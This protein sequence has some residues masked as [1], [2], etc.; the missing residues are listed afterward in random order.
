PAHG[1]VIIT[2]RV[3]SI[4]NVLVILERTGFFGMCVIQINSLKPVARLSAYKGKGGPCYDTGRTAEY[5]GGALAALDDDN[6]IL[7]GPGGASGPGGYP[8]HDGP[9]IPGSSLRST[10]ICEKTACLYL[11]S[12]YKDMVK[13][14]PANPELLDRLESEPLEFNCNSLDKQAEKL[15]RSLK[16]KPQTVGPSLAVLYPGPFRMLIMKDGS[17][18]RRGQFTL[19]P[20]SQASALKKS[21]KCL[22]LNINEA[23]DVEKPKQLQKAFKSAGTLCLVENIP[24][25]NQLRSGQD[26]HL[27]DLEKVPK[28]MRSKLKSLI[29]RKDKYFILTGSDPWDEYG[30]CPS[31]EVGAANRL[32]EAGVLTALSTAAAPG[33]CPTAIYAFNGEIKNTEN[34]PQF[35][36]NEGARKRVF[37]YIRAM[38]NGPLAIARTTIKWMLLFYVAA[39]IAYMLINPSENVSMHSDLSRLNGDGVLIYYFHPAIRCAACLNM[40]AFT[41]KT[42][43]LYYDEEKSAGTIALERVNIDDPA[44]VNLVERY[45][46]FNTTIV[47]VKQTRGKVTQQKI[48]FEQIWELFDSE[49][50]FIR[51]LN[52]ELRALLEK[53]DE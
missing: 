11:S 10:P 44:N 16:Q 42:L 31:R 13:V 27:E 1:R 2:T 25:E 20:K 5:S 4:Y 51:M 19:I 23:A 53:S 49:N 3:D 52:G 48:L 47:M 18:L 29:S 32:V 9:A 41:E 34:T 6:H 26:L 28:Q 46:I 35:T 7:F 17:M 12:A 21:D 30:C 33:A 8:D 36:I 15:V 37:D 14:S 50:E 22:L 24:F 45:G 38:R 43:K 40:E 39:A